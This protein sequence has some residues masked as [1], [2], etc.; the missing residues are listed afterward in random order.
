MNSQHWGSCNGN[1]GTSL[2]SGLFKVRWEQIKSA[3]QQSLKYRVRM[4]HQVVDV[5]YRLRV[6]SIRC[7]YLSDHMVRIVYP[8]NYTR[9]C[10]VNFAHAC[11]VCIRPF[12]L[13][14]KGLGMRL[15]WSVP[16]TKIELL[17]TM[18]EK[19]VVN[20]LYTTK[21]FEGLLV[22]FFA[23]VVF[24]SEKNFVVKVHTTHCIH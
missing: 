10:S 1:E 5:K 19:N 6:F 11:T 23:F 12:L 22:F 24:C 15:S 7:P 18:L 8:A 3:V 20:I 17:N 16:S 9:K 21:K 2:K 14:S 13:P 4:H